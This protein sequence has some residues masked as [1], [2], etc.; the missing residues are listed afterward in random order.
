MINFE[1]TRAGSIRAASEARQKMPAPSL[2]LAEPTWL[3]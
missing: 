3:T 1:Y 2:L